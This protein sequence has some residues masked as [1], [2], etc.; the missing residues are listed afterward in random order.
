MYS[1]MMVIKLQSVVL[2]A[3]LKQEVAK[4]ND[5]L[6]KQVKKMVRWKAMEVVEFKHLNDMIGTLKNQN[7]KVYCSQCPINTLYINSM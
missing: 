3:N 2:V 4:V 7:D 1:N 6:N 5:T